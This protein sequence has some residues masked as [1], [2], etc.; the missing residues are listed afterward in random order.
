MSRDRSE[1]RG[2]G[3][4]LLT[5][6]SAVTACISFLA[7]HSTGARADH[8]LCGGEV[9]SGSALAEAIGAFIDPLGDCDLISLT[10]NIDVSAPLNLFVVDMDVQT[11]VGRSLTI[12]GNGHWLSGNQATSGIIADLGSGVDPPQLTLTNLG[13]RNFSGA[14]AVSMISGSLL[15]ERS[16]FSNNV[17]A[18]PGPAAELE[19]ATAGAINTTGSLTIIES[20]FVDN[21]GSQG[22]AVASTLDEVVSVTASTFAGNS[23][24]YGGALYSLGSVVMTNSTVSGNTADNSGGLSIAGTATI[25]FSTI[26]DNR[27]ISSGAAV[28]ATNG[29]W[30]TNSIVYGN[31]LDTELPPPVFADLLTDGTLDVY[32]SYITSSSSMAST[33]QPLS[34]SGL[35]EIN[36]DPMLESLGDY[37][38]FEV[39]GGARISTRPPTAN[40]PVIDKVELIT[41]TS[42]D[43]PTDQRGP[44]YSRVVGNAADMGAVEYRPRSSETRY[45]VPGFLS[46]PEL[47][48][49]EL[50][51]TC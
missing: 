27:S 14:G 28:N 30:L 47:T 11:P 23:A 49:T 4:R 45:A 1:T 16:L 13:V 7:S 15:V 41:E 22:G 44:G 20:Q 36:P 19:D 10:A 3:L 42:D 34:S 21:R 17:Y 50:P 5:S 26:V 32:S 33:A 6:L 9:D 48:S 31:S 8:N 25:D 18:G 39:P 51:D 43:G 35:S 29:I 12:D 2:L 38:G 46:L 40:S 24:T 37:G